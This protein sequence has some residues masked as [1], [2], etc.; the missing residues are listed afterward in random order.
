MTEANFD[1]NPCPFL[2]KSSLVQE[3]EGWALVVAVGPNTRAGKA[4]AAIE[5]KKGFTPLQLKLDVVANKIAAYGSWAG[6]IIFACMIGRMYY[7]ISQE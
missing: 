3:G 2:L 5:E 7:E 1:S 4:H 6:L